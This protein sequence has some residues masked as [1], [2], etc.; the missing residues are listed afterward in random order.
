VSTR[1]ERPF[2]PIHAAPFNGRAKKA[3][4]IISRACRPRPA[5]RSIG[6]PQSD[7]DLW[8][9]SAC[10]R[11]GGAD[12]RVGRSRNRACERSRRWFERQSKVRFSNFLPGRAAGHSSISGPL[13]AAVSSLLDHSAASPRPTRHESQARAPRPRGAPM[14]AARPPIPSSS[15]ECIRAPTHQSRSFQPRGLLFAQR[16]GALRRYDLRGDESGGGPHRRDVLDGFRTRDAARRLWSPA[17][18]ARRTP[19]QKYKKTSVRGGNSSVVGT[20]SPRGSRVES[21]SRFEETGTSR[22]ERK[23]I[24]DTAVLRMRIRIEARAIH[25]WP[26]AERSPTSVDVALVQLRA[27]WRRSS[28]AHPG[29]DS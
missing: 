10:A 11:A 12:A 20:S 4:R 28:I 22:G 24:T 7:L 15:R 9:L 25:R 5:N 2:T 23:R 27:D 19:R 16:F 17:R 26:G 3:D 14:S 13:P 21:G 1:S 18:V 6:S 8:I 29:L